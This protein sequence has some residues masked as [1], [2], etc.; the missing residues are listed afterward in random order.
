MFY[1]TTKTKPSPSAK[2]TMELS[3][4]NTKFNPALQVQKPKEFFSLSIR[5]QRPTTFCHKIA[6][7]QADKK[8][9]AKYYRQQQPD[10]TTCSNNNVQ[11]V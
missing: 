9:N 8:N 2:N 1:C 5:F 11:T 3:F 10:T 4:L 6:A 7:S